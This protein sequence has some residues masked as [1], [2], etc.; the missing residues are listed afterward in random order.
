MEDYDL[1]SIKKHSFIA[2]FGH[3]IISPLAN[4]PEFDFERSVK[5]SFVYENGEEPVAALI[6]KNKAVIT[7]DTKDVYTALELLENFTTGDDIM[8][9][10][11]Q[12]PLIFTPQAEEEKTLTFPCVFLKPDASYVPGMGEDHVAR[13][14]FRAIPDPATG[15]LFTFY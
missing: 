6:Q 8:T 13:L 7:L 14:V 12:R 1:T 9:Q 11:R 4:E 10:E 5:E 15:K 2:R 3:T